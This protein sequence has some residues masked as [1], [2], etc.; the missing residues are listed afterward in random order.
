M[1]N[2]IACSASYRQIH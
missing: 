1:P 2:M